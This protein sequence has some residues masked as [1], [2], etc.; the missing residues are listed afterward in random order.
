MHKLHTNI[1][2]CTGITAAFPSLRFGSSDDP[3]D[4]DEGGDTQ[5]KEPSQHRHNQQVSLSLL[6][7]IANTSYQT[8][9]STI[10]KQFPSKQVGISLYGNLDAPLIDVPDSQL[11][12]AIHPALDLDIGLSKYGDVEFGTS[13]WKV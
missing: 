10:G 5:S 3:S 9:F 7:R 2:D 8:R 13:N 1:Y 12:T 4:E 6:Y 11:A